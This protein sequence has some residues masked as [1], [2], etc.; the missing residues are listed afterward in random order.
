MRVRLFLC[1]STLALAIGCGG[2]GVAPS[3]SGGGGGSTSTFEEKLA[4]V[5]ALETYEKTLDS[6]NIDAFLTNVA[7]KMPSLGFQGV[8]LSPEMVEAT[9]SDGRP[10]AVV[11]NRKADGP[12]APSY[13]VLPRKGELPN[14]KTAVSTTCMGPM[15]TD[16][17]ALLTG[18]TP[19]AGYVKGSGDSTVRGLIQTF[20]ND[21]IYV[22]AH[23][24]VIKGKYLLWT[25]D[26]VQKP[27]KNEDLKALY[28][29]WDIEMF[30]ASYD[31]DAQGNTIFQ[32]RYAIGARFIRKYVTFKSNC[33][34]MDNACFGDA[35]PDWKAALKEKGVSAYMG[36]TKEAQDQFSAFAA[37]FVYDKML[38]LNFNGNA[39]ENPNQRPFDLDSVYD[40]LVAQHRATDGKGSTMKLRHLRGNLGLLRPTIQNLVVKGY[41]RELQVN[42]DFGSKQ[43]TVTI[44]QTPVSVTSWTPALIKVSLPDSGPG[45]Y[46]NVVVEVNGLKSP[47]VQLSQW[48]GDVFYEDKH[49]ALLDTVD[50]KIR[51]HV[52][53]RADVH[54]YRDKP[55]VAPTEGVVV[56]T[57]DRASSCSWTCSGSQGGSV[58]WTGT[59]SPPQSPPGPNSSGSLFQIAYTIDVKTKKLKLGLIAVDKQAITI[60]NPVHKVDLPMNLQVFDERPGPFNLPTIDVQ[61]GSDFSIPE[62]TRSYTP[63]AGASLYTL[64]WNSMPTAFPPASDATHR[65]FR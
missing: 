27:E 46:G 41:E 45:A 14:G 61:L 24:G 20:N 64:Q 5:A 42:G 59:G 1:C 57:C 44:N 12:A 65:A 48:E 7:A 47:A 40:D 37:Y 34:L 56:S 49:T 8:A 19:R 26:R 17:A 39:I 54:S 28:N 25:S 10:F 11:N 63:G 32:T 51:F 36:W 43:G 21:L 33:F 18:W 55:H 58:T 3:G 31:E 2:G 22:D 4:A 30:Q 53:L 50:V 23:G 52:S 9:F 29:G 6:S 35:D 13:Q 62:G 15:F 60:S 16:V 38:G